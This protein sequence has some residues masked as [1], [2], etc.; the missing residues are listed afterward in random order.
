LIDPGILDVRCP[1]QTIIQAA[2]AALA[3][4]LVTP[5]IA[6]PVPYTICSGLPERP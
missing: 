6:A 3:V 1:M 5:A 4:I 2:M